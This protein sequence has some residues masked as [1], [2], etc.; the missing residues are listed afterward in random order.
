[1]TT[2]QIGRDTMSYSTA[3]QSDFDAAAAAYSPR[4]LS[5]ANAMPAAVYLDDARRQAWF[6]GWASAAS[7]T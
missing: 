4:L 5:A 2:I 7:R 6:C 1:M 3:C